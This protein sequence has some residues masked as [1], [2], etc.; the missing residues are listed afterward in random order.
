M[1]RRLTLRLD[2]AMRHRLEA[3]AKARQTTASSLAREALE[4]F[5]DRGASDAGVP[6]ATPD[7][8]ASPGHDREHCA[9]SLLGLCPPEVQ[10]VVRQ[11]SERLGLSPAKVLTCLLIAHLWPTSRSPDGTE[12]MPAMVNRPDMNSGG[13]A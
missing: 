1:A 13:M 3:D 5:L 6:P 11:A 7:S 8:P 4:L 10:A 2:E 12:A 9:A